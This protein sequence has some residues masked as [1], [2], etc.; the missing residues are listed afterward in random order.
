MTRRAER[1]SVMS[2]RDAVEGEPGITVLHADN[3]D[4]V[5]IE[6]SE[7]AAQRLRDTLRETHFVEP[8]VRRKLH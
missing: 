5:T 1:G 4:V 7:E 6:A 3:P 2:A 8:E